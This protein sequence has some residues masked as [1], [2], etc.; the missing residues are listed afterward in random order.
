MGRPT[1]SV[2]GLGRLGAPMVACFAAKGQR[3]I[4]VD[5]N[6]QVISQI[7]DGRAPVYEPGLND[8]IKENTEWISATDDYGAA[9]AA[10]QI[11]FI[12]VPTPSD[13]Q[14]GFSLQSVMLAVERI[15]ECLRNKS[16]FHLVVLTSTVLPGASETKIRP[17]LE[18]SSGKQCG[19]DFGLCYNPEFIALG[20]VIRDI[21][22]PDFVLIGESEKRSGDLLEAFY[23][24]L[25][26]NQPPIARM[27]IVNA[28]LTKIA[29]N[30]YVTTKISY[31]NMLAEI[32]ERIP[33]ADVDV[34][35]NALGL[36]SRIGGKYLTGASSYGGP[37]FP[38]DNL[39]F[40]YLARRLRGTAGLAEATDAINRHQLVRLERM[41]LSRLPE[42]GT[43][44]ILGLSYKPDS[45][46]IEESQGINLARSL[47]TKRIPTVL[48]DPV[49]MDTA[50]QGLGP[51]T[52]FAN[53]LEE[54]VRQADVLIIT[55]P[56]PEFREIQP[57][58][59]VRHSRRPVLI[60]CWRILDSERY[61][62]V[63][64]YVGLGIGPHI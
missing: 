45:N 17:L 6:P 15:G 30:T 16:K 47:M 49:A 20:S 19:I 50:R 48:Y 37:C 7:N 23:R 26:D 53:S 40:A 59:L 14:G 22:N 11:A 5:L 12:V 36:D 3:V 13:E 18:K 29:I 25:C 38:R 43:V 10:S 35:T 24:A 46:V 8:L 28:E 9:I 52:V 2:I 55:T 57:A 4:G 39:A 34:V 21:L 32:C 1:V 31:A 56:W 58:D 42:G 54:C 64:D 44:G 41:I 62:N 61:S 51:E 63:A 27:N 33:G 60:D